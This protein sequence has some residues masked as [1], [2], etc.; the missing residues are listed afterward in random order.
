MLDNSDVVASELFKSENVFSNGA[1]RLAVLGH[2]AHELV[3]DV[4]KWGCRDSASECKCKEGLH[5][6]VAMY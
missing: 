3:F 1:I 2:V 4:V 6:L 5:Y